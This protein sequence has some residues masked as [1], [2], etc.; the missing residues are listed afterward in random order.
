M[1]VFL[2]AIW[3]EVF[4]CVILTSISIARRITSANSRLLTEPHKRLQ[5]QPPSF[6]WQPW[7]NGHCGRTLALSAPPNWV[8]DQWKLLSFYQ[9]TLFLSPNGVISPGQTT[10]TFKNREKIKWAMTHSI[11]RCSRVRL[12]NERDCWC[13]RGKISKTHR[14]TA[15]RKRTN[16]RTKTYNV[17]IL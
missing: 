2:A 16:H 17:S 11:Q 9:A 14:Y 5:P 13:W 15:K 12:K 6:A 3:L 8:R 4:C 10:Q 7:R 1:S